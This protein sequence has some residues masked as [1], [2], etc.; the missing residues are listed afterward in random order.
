MENKRKEAKTNLENLVLSDSKTLGN[1]ATIDDD[2]QEMKLFDGYTRSIHQIEN[3]TIDEEL[4]KLEL[5]RKKFELEEARRKAIRDAAEFEARR[6]KEEAEAAEREAKAAE[7][8][9]KEAKEKKIERR[10]WWIDLGVK[11][12]TTILTVGTPLV[13]FFVS[14]KMEYVDNKIPTKDMNTL[15]GKMI[16]SKH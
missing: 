4:K 13:M 12:G 8:E 1:G 2:L 6:E 11:V 14:K 5:R 10:R 15:W 9:E 3:D 7:R 16:N